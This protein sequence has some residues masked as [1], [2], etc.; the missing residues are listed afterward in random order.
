MRARHIARRGVGASRDRGGGRGSR[1]SYLAGRI[2]VA[3][4]GLLARS[5]LAAV[6]GRD[7]PQPAAAGRAVVRG[8]DGWVDRREDCVVHPHRLAERA[9]EMTVTRGVGSERQS[10]A[11][12]TATVVEPASARHGD[13]GGSSRCWFR[14][15]FPRARRRVGRESHLP[16]RGR[17]AAHPSPSC[18]CGCARRD[19][20][21]PALCRRARCRRRCRGA[22]RCA[23][24]RG[25]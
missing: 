4:R 18:T 13:V 25:T 14:D 22:R 15:A 5:H 6:R 3:D 12:A 7:D 19:R 20:E 24:A 11:R 9:R 21:G 2:A 16:W 17:A 8:A 23:R 10:L 1:G